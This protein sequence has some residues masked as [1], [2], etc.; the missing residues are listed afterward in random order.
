M[1]SGAAYVYTRSSGV[2][3]Q[4]AYVKASN[5]E[6]N[7][8]FGTVVALSGDGNTLAVGAPSE[9]SG[10][11]GVTP[12][13]VSE[14]T[15]LNATFSSGATYVFLR[16]A[17]TW[18]QQA[19]VKASNTGNS[20]MFGMWVAL[21]SDGNTLAVGAPLEDG[22]A[23]GV[24]GT[25]DDLA[26]DAGAAYVYSRSGTAWSF[27]A[28]VKASNTGSGDHFGTG[29][30]LSGDGNTL[31]VGAPFENSAARGIGGNQ[32]NDCAAG[33]PLNCNAASGAA[34]VYTRSGG[35][36]SH[37]AYVKASNTENAD[38]FGWAIGL[39]GDGN[40]LA[41]GAP[42]EGGGATGIGPTQDDNNART[43]GAAYLY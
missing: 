25:P 9:S 27:Q 40:T 21:S 12:G 4:Q 13:S 20:D 38:R 7:D 42:M 36:W 29:L 1:S 26:A 32:V 41:A 35:T 10:L 24:G 18:A 33:V 39:N 11:T 2:W 8:L 23:T 3:T 15:A 31:A 6:E 19:Y 16:T 14:A 37:K 5:T 28:Y 34:Y 30:A 43:S 17:G 22:G